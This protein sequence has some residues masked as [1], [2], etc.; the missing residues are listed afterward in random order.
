MTAT[1]LLSTADLQS[2]SDWFTPR[3]LTDTC[4]IQREINSLWTPVTGLT[5]V[6]CAVTGD[7]YEGALPNELVGADLKTILFPRNTD[8]RSPDRLLINGILYRVFDMQGPIT[9]EV[10]RSVIVVRFP[11]RGGA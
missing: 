8:V 1:P 2:L 7:A 5:A 9:D 6:P 3:F 4:Q 10:L 11:Q